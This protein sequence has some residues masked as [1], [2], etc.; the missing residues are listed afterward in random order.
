MSDRSLVRCRGCNADLPRPFSR[1]RKHAAC[2]QLSQTGGRRDG[3]RNSSRSRFRIATG[4]IYIQL[5]DVVPP[6]K[7]FTEY[8]YFSSYSESFLKHAEAMALAY[9]ARFA[10]D[11]RSRV[12]E[13]ASNDGYLL[14]HFVNRKIPV[15]GVEPARNIAAEAQRRGIPT[16]NRFFG[17]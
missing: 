9:I 1:P 10:L 15:L 5:T 14:Q 16:L 7:L 2:Q 6:A 17:T 11:S 8:L 13:I 12:L 4:A 3:R